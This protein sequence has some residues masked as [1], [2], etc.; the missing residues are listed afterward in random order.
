[1]REHQEVENEGAVHTTQV[2]CRAGRLGRCSIVT[3]EALFP[4]R[5]LNAGAPD[6]DRSSRTTKRMATTIYRKRPR[7]FRQQQNKVRAWR[8]GPKRILTKLSLAG[9]SNSVAS[10]SSGPHGLN[11]GASQKE[12]H[13]A[14]YELNGA[15]SVAQG[16]QV[17]CQ[18][19]SKNEPG[20][21]HVDF[22]GLMA[23]F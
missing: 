13:W 1:M 6:Q 11:Q 9:C 18:E 19:F 10:A 3:N 16:S 8:Q 21:K 7:D 15:D 4:R 2:G 14:P 12:Q 22:A 20:L 23:G 5:P 17:S